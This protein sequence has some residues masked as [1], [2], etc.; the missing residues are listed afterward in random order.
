MRT[1]AG[2]GTSAV[3]TEITLV[4][5]MGGFVKMRTAEEKLKHNAYMRAWKAANPDKYQAS[6]NR[7]LAKDPD[8]F[9]RKSR[10]WRQENPDR[11]YKQKRRNIVRRYGLTPESYAALVEKQGGLCAICLTKPTRDFDIDHCHQT[12]VVRGL[13]CSHCN[14]AIGMFRDDVERLKSAIQYLLNS[15]ES[16]N[17]NAQTAE[18]RTCYCS[19]GSERPGSDYPCCSETEV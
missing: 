15:K 9:R 12:G 8:Y 7:L 11:A 14:K 1:A 13:L 17:G 2:A 4:S 6:M 18:P 16:S 19:S 3:L 5:P 10:Q